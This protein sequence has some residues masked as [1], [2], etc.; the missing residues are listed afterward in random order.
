MTFVNASFKFIAINKLLFWMCY[1]KLFTNKLILFWSRSLY[2]FRS[3]NWV[4]KTL[5]DLSET[6]LHLYWLT[7]VFKTIY[8][9]QLLVYSITRTKRYLIIMIIVS[10]MLHLHWWSFRQ[11]TFTITWCNYAIPTCLG[12]L[13]WGYTNRSVPFVLCHPRWPRQIVGIISAWNR[14]CLSQW[15]WCWVRSAKCY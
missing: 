10:L 7:D 5:P 6:N 2:K 14:K 15:K 11:K 13:G 4:K 8:S 12:H 9:V 3:S 1:P